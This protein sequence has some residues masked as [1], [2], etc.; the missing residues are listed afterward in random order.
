MAYGGS[1]ARGLIRAVAA[2]LYQSSRQCWIL[3]PLSKAR[4]PK[5]NLMVPSRIRFRCAMTGPP[6]SHP[7]ILE[8]VLCLDVLGCLFVSVEGGALRNV[9]PE[10]GRWVVKPVSGY[11]CTSPSLYLLSLGQ[12]LHILNKYCQN[13]LSQ[14][15]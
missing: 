12:C 3:N 1:Q 9:P 11:L 2:G 14:L 10:T 4:D 7:F 6:W 13:N 8:I 15:G 5:R